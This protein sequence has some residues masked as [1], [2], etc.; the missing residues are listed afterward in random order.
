MGKKRNTFLKTVSAYSN[1]GD[2]EIVFGVNDDMQIAKPEIFECANGDIY[3]N[4]LIKMIICDI[5]IASTVYV[6]T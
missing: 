4:L 2:G 6:Y 3:K 5:I 1:F